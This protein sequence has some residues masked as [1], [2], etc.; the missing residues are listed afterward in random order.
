MPD[1]ARFCKNNDLI[2][3]EFLI[4]IPGSVGGAITMNA[5]A[6]GWE[7][8]DLFVSLDAYNFIKNDYETLD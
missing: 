4:G 1:L 7:F 6:Y 2:N 5:G 3:S 8:S